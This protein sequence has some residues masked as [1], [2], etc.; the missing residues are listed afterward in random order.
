MREPGHGGSAWITP[1]AGVVGGYRVH[2]HVA[3]R[4]DV[5]VGIATIRP[6]FVLEPHGPV[7]EVGGPV[8][9]LSGSVEARF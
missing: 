2:E 3:L 8:G 5:A 9:L 6:A 4:L 1:F 7:Y